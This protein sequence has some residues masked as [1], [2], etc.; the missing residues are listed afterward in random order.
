MHDPACRNCSAVLT[1]PY[2]AQCGQHAHES[3]KSLHALLHDAWHL[4]THL[5]GRVWGTLRLLLLKPGRLTGEY[6]ADHRAGYVPPF[7]LYFVISVAFFALASLT[8]SVSNTLPSPDRAEL[9]QELHDELQ[10]SGTPPVIATTLE[11]M[12]A[13]GLSRDL[14]TQMC[15]HLAIGLPRVDQRLQSVCRHQ[16]ADQGKSMMHAFR[17]LIPKMMFV[18]LPLMA[19]IMLLLYHSPP[20]LYVEHL[21]FLLHLQSALFLAMILAM[22]LTAAADAVPQLNLVATIG[23]M[24][25]F[26][27]GLW[28]VY[29]AMRRC[30]LQGRA[31]TLGKAA[32]LMVAYSTC[33]VLALGGT[34]LLSAVLT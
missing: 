19:L 9:Q 17:S 15:G 12:T 11:D 31:R 16:L 4:F 25:L 1:G 21:V 13:H 3:A 23:G 18:F 2:C 6:F 28:Y 24:I 27:Y 22:L 32:L 33:L 20:R 14:A 8:T 30:Y 29:A 5:D 7:R 10:H 26:W 34:V